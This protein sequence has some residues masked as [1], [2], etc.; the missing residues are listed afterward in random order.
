MTAL[1]KGATRIKIEPDGEDSE[2]PPAQIDVATRDMADLLDGSTPDSGGVV[3]GVD[4]SAER[5]AR[6]DAAAAAHMAATEGASAAQMAKAHADV[7]AAQAAASARTAR[8]AE[9]LEEEPGDEAE[10]GGDDAKAGGRRKGSQGNARKKAGKRTAGTGNKTA[11][12]ADDGKQPPAKQ[13]TLWDNFQS[14]APAGQKVEGYERV[15]AAAEGAGY[16]TDVLRQTIER[17][18][19][20]A[21][22]A[23]R[24]APP[25]SDG[26]GRS[27]SD[28]KYAI[29][30]RIDETARAA[31]V[32]A[33][34]RDYAKTQE[35]KATAAGKGRSGGWQVEGG[36]EAEKAK[37]YASIGKGAASLVKAE[38]QDDSLGTTDAAKIGLKALVAHAHRTA[39]KASGARADV[40]REAVRTQIR[41][42]L[43]EADMDLEAV[44]KAMDDPQMNAEVDEQ[45]PPARTPVNE[46][47]A[48]AEP[49]TINPART[50]PPG[51][52]ARGAVTPDT[53]G[54]GAGADEVK[55]TPAQIDA[56]ALAAGM[57]ASL[58][59]A[60]AAR[61]H[62][63]GAAAAR[64]ASEARAANERPD[65]CAAAEQ[66]G[67]NGEAKDGGTRDA[68]DPLQRA[69][70]A[71]GE[72]PD[73][74]VDEHGG[75]GGGGSAASSTARA[76]A[77]AHARASDLYDA[78]NLDAMDGAGGQMREA[79][80][81]DEAG[82]AWARG[83]STNSACGGAGG[84]GGSADSVPDEVGR[85]SGAVDGDAPAPAQEVVHVANERSTGAGGA[86]TMVV[87]SG[88]V[89]APTT[90]AATA[91]QAAGAG[92]RECS[93]Q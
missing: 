15:A 68:A 43:Q 7:A 40:C 69:A 55:Q 17:A 35:G 1:E 32:E 24:L 79:Q 63:A 73:R 23:A 42:A 6:F 9:Q 36:A 19:T 90:N 8:A 44:D 25:E 61:A 2:V 52:P 37:L 13:E 72:K 41:V 82:A 12:G 80:H 67:E 70:P 83:A 26:S 85:E 50:R 47:S 62:D 28:Y 75:G 39:E 14:D 77:D 81:R 4:W 48:E 56:A 76:L 78:E 49:G 38:K 10:D 66:V 51:K 3:A 33:A 16:S 59:A 92:S 57:E 45:V 11:K 5:R 29:R 58:E 65:G 31:A 84:A 53:A 34:M 22:G 21:A 60:R 88:V 46:G 27:G 87:L 89:R 71:E 91:A 20:P 86:T 30:P 93:Q 74:T 64:A 54:T 18:A